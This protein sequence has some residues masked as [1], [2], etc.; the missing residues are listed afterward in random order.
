[1]ISVI[2]LS[3]VDEKDFCLVAFVTGT[4]GLLVAI[5]LDI[6]ECPQKSRVSTVRQV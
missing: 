4:I 5:P 1:M 6:R 3:S 2:V